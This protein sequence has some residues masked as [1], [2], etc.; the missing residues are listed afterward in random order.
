MSFIQSLK[1]RCANLSLFALATCLAGLNRSAPTRDE[2][3]FAARMLHSLGPVAPS[4]K[5]LDLSDGR[6][7]GKTW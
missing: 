6:H 4:A 5:R 7:W 3:E 2:Q 1:D